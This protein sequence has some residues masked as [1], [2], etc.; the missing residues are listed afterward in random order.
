MKQCA[1][2]CGVGVSGKT[3]HGVVR[4]F[5]TGH[6]L[7]VLKRT[8]AHRAAISAAQTRAWRTK[9]QRLP[10]GSRAIDSNGYVRVKTVPGKGKW[11]PEHQIVMAQ[12]MGRPLAKGEVV[13]H[14][15]GDRS[16]N[17][18]SNLFLCRNA[19]HHNE[20]HRSEAAALR[21]LLAA[22]VVVFRDGRYEALLRTD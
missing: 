21:A 15:N 7:R 22:G 20:V 10:V 5:V 3:P 1:C 19:S 12:L 9:R 17:A 11:L 2:G 4:R 13:H 16:D 6:N 8:A 14:V 18:P